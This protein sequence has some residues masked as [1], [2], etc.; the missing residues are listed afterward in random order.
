MNGI[1][2]VVVFV[3]EDGMYEIDTVTC[4]D[5]S[6]A[7]VRMTEQYRYYRAL[8]DMNNDEIY[9]DDV[10]FEIHRTNGDKY[11]GEIKKC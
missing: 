1:F 10:S 2:I 4:T 11:I 9:V 5:K 3:L 7:Q 6:D 8:S